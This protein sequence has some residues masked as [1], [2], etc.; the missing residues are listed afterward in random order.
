MSPHTAKRAGRTTW[1]AALL[2]M[3]CSQTP[4]APREVTVPAAREAASSEPSTTES[5]PYSRFLTRF[6]AALENSGESPE[7]LN[8]FVDPTHGVLLLIN[9]GALT[10]VESYRSY[11]EL[12]R[13]PHL[14]GSLLHSKMGCEGELHSLSARLPQ[15]S[16]D[17][18]RYD[19]PD[20][21]YQGE[22]KSG[23]LRRHV[24]WMQEYLPPE[25]PEAGR[26]FTQL[27]AKVDRSEPLV[28]HYF[29]STRV[30]RGYFFGQ[31]GG[32][33]R[34]IWVDAVSPCSA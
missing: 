21:C 22:F 30:S 13:T 9:P 11:S 14:G 27:M 26:E 28:T 7:A 2:A 34:L 3:G 12:A 16:C 31:V 1:A 15:F 32:A 25:T 4:P 23:V 19:V 18:E 6:L 8:A 5:E 24:V 29:F 10:I 20:S 33:W 17:D